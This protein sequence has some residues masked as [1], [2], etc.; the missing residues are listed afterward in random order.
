MQL[1]S[2]CNF[3]VD[4]RPRFVRRFPYRFALCSLLRVALFPIVVLSAAN[5]SYLNPIQKQIHKNLSLCPPT[6]LGFLKNELSEARLSLLKV[7]NDLTRHAGVDSFSL[8][9]IKLSRLES[10]IAIRALS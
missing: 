2:L 7:N 10:N 6:L 4:F 9:A 8:D 3:K 5:W 1:L